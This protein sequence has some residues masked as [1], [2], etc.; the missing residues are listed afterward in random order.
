[1]SI[2]LSLLILCHISRGFTAVC[3]DSREQFRPITTEESRFAADRVTQS[4]D[5]E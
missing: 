3:K 1:M 5:H 4:F 2:F